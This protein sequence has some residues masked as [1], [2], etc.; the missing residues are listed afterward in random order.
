MADCPV[1]RVYLLDA[2]Y[3]IDKLYDYYIPYDLRNIIC[4]GVFAAVPFG[5]GNRK[6]RALVTEVTD[7]SDLIIENLKP[8]FSIV[9]EGITL[10][11]EQ[12]RLCEFIKE[13]TFCTIGDVVRTILP[14]AASS[15][16]TIYY[17]IAGDLPDNTHSLT[18]KAVFVYNRISKYEHITQQRLEKELS[19]SAEDALKELIAGGYIKRDIEFGEVTNKHFINYI[20]LTPGAHEY[21]NGE[22]K[23]RSKK[24]L[25][26]LLEINENHRVS[27]SFIKEKLRVTSAQI[28]SLA[29]KNLIL[30]EKIDSYRNPYENNENN[31]A[32]KNILNDEQKKAKEKLSALYQSNTAKAALLHGITGSGKTRVIIAMTDEVLA[33]G[34]QVIILVPEIALTPQTLSLFRMYY[35][36]DIA[37]LHSSLSAGERFD[38]YRRMQNGLAKVCIGTRSAIFAPFSNIG[39]IVIDEEQEHT[40]KSD[41]NPKYQAIDVARFRCAYHNAL[42]LLSS[43]TPSLTS[44]YKAQTGIYTLVELNERY[45]DSQLPNA[46]ICDMREDYHQG[47]LSAIGNY[48]KNEIS[49]T[50]SSNEQAIIFLNRRGYNNYVSCPQCGEVIMCP[51]CSVSLTHHTIGGHN[52]SQ[53]CCHYCG[54]TVPV[55]KKC[56]KCG[57]EHLQYMGYG[58]QKVEEELSEMF[59]EGQIVRMDADTTRTKFSY[60]EILNKFRSHEGDILLGTQMVTKGHDFPDVTL[61][62]VLLADMSL[63]LDDFRAGERTFSLITQVIGRSG[64]ASRNGKAVIQTFNPDHPVLKCA[65]AQDYKTFYKNEIALRRSLVFP[66]FCD[67]FLIVISGT[68]ENEVHNASKILALKIKELTLAS[69]NVKLV[70]FGPFEA[71]IYKLNEKYRMRFVIKGKSNSPTRL[72]FKKLLNDMLRNIGKRLNISIDVNP[73]SL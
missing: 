53:L 19:E 15:K 49:K 73:N 42:M 70:V 51:H 55:P 30:I 46:L 50:L 45:G 32:D 58:T 13:Q 22:K 71:P 47:K 9:S 72:L 4:A 11:E 48:L 31:Q 23:L 12:M 16:L 60:D 54:Y 20:E 63:Y 39:M 3:Q 69:D 57:G 37:V 61:S 34:R 62:G 40:Y 38:A 5:G 25:D 24:L 44:Y 28:K 35:G 65:A 68:S 56:P 1:A 43:A 41:A 18:S 27:D 10:N 14:S 36:N 26:I 64:R 7:K 6:Q 52:P 21:I 8:L 33:S 29:D 17:T 59:P 66:P 2:P 67:I